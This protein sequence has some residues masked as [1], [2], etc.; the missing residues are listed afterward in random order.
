MSSGEHLARYITKQYNIHLIFRVE[1]Q[2]IFVWRINDV[3]MRLS[4]M[5]LQVYKAMLD[6]GQMVAIRRVKQGAQFTTEVELLSR[7]RHNNL[8]DLIGFCVERGEGMLLYDYM[9]NGSLQHILFGIW[10]Y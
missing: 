3:L 10:N 5:N 9:A 4:E 8:L 1:L 2:T 6:D 7:L